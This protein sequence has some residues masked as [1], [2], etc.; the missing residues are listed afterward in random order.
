M[1]RGAPHGPTERSAQIPATSLDSLTEHA[2]CSVIYAML[3]SRDGHRAAQLGLRGPAQ[4]GHPV[5]KLG[6]YV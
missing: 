2:F 1:S 6:R 3:V 4:P 5:K